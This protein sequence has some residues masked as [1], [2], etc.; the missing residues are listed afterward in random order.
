MATFRHPMRTLRPGLALAA[1]VAASVAGAGCIYLPQTIS[2][3]D[4]DC[5]IYERQMQLQMAEVGGFARC[6]NDGCVALLVAAG[7][8]T[9]TSAVVSGSIVITGNVVYWFEKRGRCAR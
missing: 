1:C 2:V 5:H 7:A 4:A 3:Y 8:V 6:V 9:A